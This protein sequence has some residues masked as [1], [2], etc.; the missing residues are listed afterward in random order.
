MNVSLLMS[1][2]FP[3]VQFDLIDI[4]G[5]LEEISTNIKD[6]RNEIPDHI[7][8]AGYRSHSA[9]HNLGPI[10]LFLCIYFG[11]VVFLFFLLVIRRFTIFTLNTMKAQ[12]LS[13]WMM[14]MLFFKAY[15]YMTVQCYFEL[16]ISGMLTFYLPPNPDGSGRPATLLAIYCYVSVLGLLLLFGHV[17]RQDISQFENIYF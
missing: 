14:K 13:H 2:L 9:M 3:I 15:I 5:L 17:L 16:L 7:R 8:S 1:I 6:V 11:S 12:E 4:S 10:N